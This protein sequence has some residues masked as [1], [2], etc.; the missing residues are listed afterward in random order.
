MEGLVQFAVLEARNLLVY[1]IGGS[2]DPYYTLEHNKQIIKGTRRER[3]LNPVWSEEHTFKSSPSEKMT[4]HLYDWDKLSKDDYMG[5]VVIPP[6]KLNSE[7]LHIE[8]FDIQKS[9][10]PRN[11]GQIRLAWK[12]SHD[13]KDPSQCRPMLQ[14]LKQG[15]LMRKTFTLH[16]WRQCWVMVNDYFLMWKKN[17]TGPILD[18]VSLRNSVLSKYQEKDRKYC[19]KI[20]HPSLNTRNL[21]LQASSGEDMES[22]IQMITVGITGKSNPSWRIQG[23]LEIKVIEAKNLLPSDR[24]GLSDPYAVLMVER[25]AKKT[26]T[27]RNNLNPIWNEC[28]T[29][30]VSNV[31]ADLHIMV[32]DEDFGLFLKNDYIGRATFPVNK[33]KNLQNVDVWVPLQ[34]VKDTSKSAGEIHLVIS[35]TLDKYVDAELKTKLFGISLDIIVERE[36]SGLP[37]PTL[38]RNAIEYITQN[39]L[40]TEGLFRISGNMNDLEQY[41][42][43]LD[44]GAAFDLKMEKNVHTVAGLLKLYIR[45]LPEPAFTYELYDEFLQ[46][47]LS[48]ESKKDLSAMKVAL[49]K[50]PP[51]NYALLKELFLFLNL[52]SRYSEKNKMTVSNLAIV[53]TPNVLRAS[54]VG[55][56]NLMNL[57][58]E[59]KVVS[60]LI[61]SSHKFFSSEKPEKL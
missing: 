8:W 47:L 35:Y 49:A 59:N 19:F 15:Y 16:S 32:F 38:V 2:S 18:Y 14:P 5:Y 17:E 21:F 53:F 33:F 10:D 9:E 31:T 25:E 42:I 41:R 43:T 22:W 56:T 55:D 44:K 12:C 7:D 29:L 4:V 23:H 52:V 46:A 50:L 60:V 30:S 39:G 28:F 48:L 58:K 3:T 61:E 57:M 34:N 37:V 11:H 36:N 45:E 1:D 51:A 6:E 26:F 54:S 20:I 27:I 24:N 13:K 40:E